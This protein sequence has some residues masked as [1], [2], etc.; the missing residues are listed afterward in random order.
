M[1]ILRRPLY[2]RRVQT[3]MLYIVQLVLSFY[4]AM[5]YSDGLAL[6]ILL[7]HFLYKALLWS[8]KLYE[9]AWTLFL[10]NTL[11]RNW[12]KSHWPSIHVIL[13]NSSIILRS[14]SIVTSWPWLGFPINSQNPGQCHTLHGKGFINFIETT[15]QMSPCWI[16]FIF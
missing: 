13:G 3:S 5:F 16:C 2:G 10:I 4:H 12:P 7:P 6:V 9:G 11:K 15:L 8:K 1:S 14:L